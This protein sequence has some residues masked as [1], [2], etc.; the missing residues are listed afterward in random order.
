MADV[1]SL[2]DTSWSGPAA[3]EMITRAVTST[4]TVDKG[5]AY[6]KS[7]IRKYYT[8]PR[9]ET[10]NFMQ[11]RQA[12]PTSQGTIT[13]DGKVLEPQDLMLYMEFN[14]RDFEA[15]FYAENL[16]DRI[17]ARDMPEPAQA[18]FVMQLTKRLNEYWETAWWQSRLKYNPDYGSGAETPPSSLSSASFYFFDGWLEKLLTDD[19]VVPFPSAVALTYS[20]IRDQFQAA[21]LLTPLAVRYKYG[22]K[23]LRILVS[24][25]DQSKYE[26]A[27]RLDA[28]K[29]QD[30][31]SAGIN[32][33][34]GYDV[35]PL[36][37]LPENTFIMCFAK[38]DIDGQLWIGMNSEDD[39]SLQLQRLQNNSELFF[40][41]G[42]F[43]MDTQTG[44]GDQIVLYT[45]L[46]A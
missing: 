42:L 20:N 33:W 13:V 34:A 41:K 31:S 36:A 3:Q 46:T 4:D 25:A 1:I 6:I 18:Y 22:L 27:L 39:M 44:F 38:P 9:I 35:V 30:T 23:G 19:T 24:Y 40:I 11:A 5:C 17:L 32:K 43:K 14:P 15:H 37:G 45:T 26:E 29:N 12:T 2:L 28:Y 10:N 8:I 7:G 21:F 16:E